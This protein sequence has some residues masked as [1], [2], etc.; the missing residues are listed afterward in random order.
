MA[1]ICWSSWRLGR[2]PGAGVGFFGEMC[3]FRAKIKWVMRKCI[4]FLLLM[5][6][7][8][9]TAWG[10][11]EKTRLVV[12]ITVNH[13]YPEWLEMYGYGLSDKGLKRIMGGGGSVADYGYMYSQTGVD[14]ATIYTGTV[15]AEHGIVAHEWYDRLRGGRQND[16]ADKEFRLI[17]EEGEGVSPN[18]MQALTL[19]CVMKMNN[20]F[21]KV[22]SIGANAEEAVLGGGSCANLALWLSDKTG[23]WVSSSF[24]ADSLP[25]WLGA[26]NAK[27]ESDHFI[28]RGWMPL[29]DEE[30]NLVALKL[31]SKVGMKEGFYYDLIQAKRKYETYRILKATPYVNTMVADLAG[32]LVRQEQLGRDNDTDLLALNFSCLDY[33]NR[34]YDVR[35]KEFQD[36]V[37]RL[38][39][40]VERLLAVLD[41]KVGE[42]NYTVFL[43][44]AEARELLP[45][46]LQKVR[47]PSGY[48][49]IFKAVALMKSFLGLLYGEGDWILD[50]DASQIYLD[51]A[52]LEKHKIPLQEMQDGGER[53]AEGRGVLSEHADGAV[54]GGGNVRDEGERLRGVSPGHQLGHRCTCVSVFC[55]GGRGRLYAI[56]VFPRGDGQGV[57]EREES[58]KPTEAHA[59]KGQEVR[60][61]GKK[62]GEKSAKCGLF[63]YF[64][65]MK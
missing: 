27:V 42:G 34:D 50:Y 57:T 44:F 30:G 19:G 56:D 64:W 36:V 63:L 29:E 14:Q 16:V 38:D 5:L 25:G 58:G 45:E 43:T 54:L 12:G 49:S 59:G 62:E 47:V 39:K 22:Y 24:Y 4:A 40:D 65:D 35:S 53:P 52:L 17:G 51:R 28:R 23:K 13:F 37:M 32:E 61:D 6:A 2:I 21:A 20:A 9:G 60:R 33:M 26:Y 7:A 11:G 48:F 55:T 46:D 41:E 15:P 1:G 10:K 3:Y 18:G 31:K 8:G